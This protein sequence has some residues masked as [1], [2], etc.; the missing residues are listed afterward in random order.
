MIVVLVLMRAFIFEFK[1]E[2][3]MVVTVGMVVIAVTVGVWEHGGV[4]CDGGNDSDGGCSN[5]LLL[6]NKLPPKL[7]VSK[8]H[9]FITSCFCGPGI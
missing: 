7:N 6:P 5:Y 4:G 1:V 2:V 8:Q 3:G 9:T